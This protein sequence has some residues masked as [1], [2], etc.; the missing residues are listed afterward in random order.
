MRKTNRRFFVAL[1][2]AGVVSMRHSARAGAPAIYNLGTLGGSASYGQALNASGEV[3]G[4]SYVVGD[5]A[6]HAFLYTG[7]GGTMVDLGTF[8]G[9]VSSHGYGINALGQ[10]VG[11]AGGSPFGGD[12]IYSGV[13]GSGG[14][15]YNL[16]TLGGNTGLAFA[17]NASGQVTGWSGTQIGG[18]FH[19]FLYSGVPGAGGAMVDLGTLGGSSEGTA[20]NDNGQVA[21]DSVTSGGA[22][23]AFLF[24]GIPGNGGAMADLGSLGGDCFTFGINSAGQVVG[25]SLTTTTSGATHAFLYTG[26]PGA[27]GAMTDLGPGVAAAINDQGDVVGWNG[28]HAFIWVGTHMIDLNDWLKANDPTDAAKW[29]LRAALGVTDTGLIAGS[30]TYNDGPGGMSDG[31]RA[32]LLDAS[33]LVVPEPASLVLL[34]LGGIGLLLWRRMSLHERR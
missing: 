9:G 28:S 32:F 16:G 23:H 12:F 21:G 14:M 19:A 10:V 22:L 20:I 27:G 17:V 25:K 4:Y 30:G 24:S 8:P 29:T 5:T 34:G 2:L 15:M 31:D 6:Y 33:S 11:D 3:A 18:P 7:P 1:L 13:P 26:T